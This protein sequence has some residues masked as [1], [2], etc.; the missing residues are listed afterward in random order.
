M[1]KWHLPAQFLVTPDVCLPP[2]SELPRSLWEALN[3]LRTG[4]GRFGKCLYRWSILDTPKCICGAEEQS[5]NHLIFDWNI[6]RPPN[7]LEDLL[8][9]TSTTL[10]GLRTLWVLFKPL[11]AQEE[12]W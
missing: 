1:G 11:L 5:A 9:L 10:N 12:D 8:S 2:G 3:R 7:C 6:L 4:V